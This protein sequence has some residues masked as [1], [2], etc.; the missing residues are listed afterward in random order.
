MKKEISKK[1]YQRYKDVQWKPMDL[2]ADVDYEWIA[3]SS[4]L[5]WLELDIEI[6][7]DKILRE[8]QNIK[9]L[10][11]PHRD[12]YAENAGWNSFCIHGQSYNATREDIYYDHSQPYQYTKEAIDLMP[13]TVQYFKDV[14]PHLSYQRLRVM[15]LKPNGYISLHKDNDISTLSPINIAITHPL[16]CGFVMAKYGT[17]PFEPGR[18]FVLDVSN[19]H[20]IFNNSQQDRWH[21][22]VHQNSDDKFKDLVVKSYKKLY[23]KFYEESNNNNPR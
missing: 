20:T 12:D 2:T 14:W 18:A 11:V 21:I 4:Q 3:K 1:F 22:I 9:H 5:P 19:H 15:Q 8:I 13:Y 23:N 17:V 10:C 7:I 6:P 16:D